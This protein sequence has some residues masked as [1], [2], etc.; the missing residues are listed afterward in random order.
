MGLKDAG[1]QKTTKRA[2]P[3]EGGRHASGT[4]HG[5]ESPAGTE[6]RMEAI[7]ERANLLA[8]LKRVKENGGAPGIDKMTVEALPLYLKEA[9]PELKAQLLEG[10]YRPCAVRRVEVEKPGGGKRKLGIPTAVDRFIQQAILQVLQ[11]DWDATFSE[12]SY[13]FRPGRSAHQAVEQAQR[14]IQEGYGVVVDID[15][16]AF[17][18]RV[19]HDKL[20]GRVAKRETDKRLLRL[21]RAY[22]NAGV[23]ENG[24]VVRTEEGMPQGGPLSPL[25]SNLLLDDLDKE[26]E[27]RGHRFVRYADDCNIYVKTER[28]GERVMEGMRTFLEKKLKLK[29]NEGKSAVG[30]PSKRKFLGFTFT[31]DKQ[32]RIHLAPRTVERFKERIR[33][34]TR[35]SWGVG[36]ERRLKE[37]GQYLRGWRGYF[38][39]CQTSKL[40]RD[41]D[42]WVRRRL[43]AALWQEWRTSRR[44]YRALRNLGLKSDLAY[45]VVRSCHGPWRLSKTESLHRALNNKWFTRMGLP[46][47]AEK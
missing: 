9:W 23:M 25:L 3:E 21:V 41:L 44:R 34:L 5:T 1:T 31:R 16:E 35:R 4:T 17:F 30:P 29:V 14:Y 43:R 10:R 22:L 38:K 45:S 15:L 40:L 27:R 46:S 7:V 12:Q 37:L 26:L 13:G 11:R 2:Y 47:I 42:S 20:M 6:R 8:A 36:F 18:D 19:N 39:L 32:A 24:V 33:E 28:A